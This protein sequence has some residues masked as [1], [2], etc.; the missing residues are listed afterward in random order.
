MSPKKK[1]VLL[2]DDDEDFR[3]ATRQ[4]LSSSDYEIIEADSGDRGLEAAIKEKPDV[5]LVDIIMDTYTEGF[6]LIRKLAEAP[7]TSGIP[8]IIL[9]SL[10]LVQD[11][12]RIYPEELGTRAIL[13]KPVRREDLLGAVADAMSN[14][15]KGKA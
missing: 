1:T 8:R 7:E 6:D 12:D 15:T 9:S 2:I 10:N 5:I 13:Q 14:E 4:I 11:V 3:R